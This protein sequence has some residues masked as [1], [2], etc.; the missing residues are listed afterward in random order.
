MWTPPTTTPKLYLSNIHVA[1][2]KH[3]MLKP[4]YKP[5]DRDAHRDTHKQKSNKK[6]LLWFRIAGNLSHFIQTLKQ[7][8]HCWYWGPN[9]ANCVFL[10]SVGPFCSYCRRSWNRSPANRLTRSK[11]GRLSAVD[12]VCVV[13]IPGPVFTL[14]DSRVILSDASSACII[15]CGSRRDI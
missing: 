12:F 6:L 1:Y 8:C 10:L 3:K 4:T 11:P 7:N 2:I 14:T 13:S 9:A 15:L 5:G